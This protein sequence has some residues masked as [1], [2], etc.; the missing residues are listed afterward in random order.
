M[1]VLVM[2]KILLTLHVW[3]QKVM[4]VFQS[5]NLLM[6]VTK[7]CIIDPLKR[8]LVVVPKALLLGTGKGTNFYPDVGS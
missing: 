3:G 5:G 4:K 8:I 7:Y 2:G 1:C 6:S